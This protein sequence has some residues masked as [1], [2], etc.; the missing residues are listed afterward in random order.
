M[1]KNTRCFHCAKIAKMKQ[2]TKLP[3]RPA[4]VAIAVF[5]LTVI[6]GGGAAFFM[7]RT[8][9]S[10]MYIVVPSVAFGFILSY[11]LIGVSYR[12]SGSRNFLM[13]YIGAGVFLSAIAALM[14][15]MG[16]FT[17]KGTERHIEEATVERVFSRKEHHT[18]RVGRRYVSSGQSYK[19]YYMEL[20]FRDGQKK[21]I[22]LGRNPSQRYRKGTR[23]ELSVEKGL[24]GIPVIKSDLYGMVHNRK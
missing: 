3:K 12:I 19:V 5:I 17:L 20:V 2:T 11:L 23:L 13:N 4:T 1:F 21:Q 6:S 8:L 9:M 7:G 22:R 14:F 15:L 24:F 10:A 16:N 18:R